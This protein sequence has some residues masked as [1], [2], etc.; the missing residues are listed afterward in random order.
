M[1]SVRPDPSTPRRK[2]HPDW[3]VKKIL[4]DLNQEYNLGLDLRDTSTLTPSARQERAKYDENF[5]R[6]SL[7]DAGVRFLLFKDANAWQN[8]LHGFRYEAR[9]VSQNWIRKPLGDP[10]TLPSSAEIRKATRVGEQLQLQEKLLEFIDEAKQM[11]LA[12]SGPVS[13]IQSD[14]DSPAVHTRSTRSRPKRPSTDNELVIELGTAKR[15]RSQARQQS[16]ILPVSCSIDKVPIRQKVSFAQQHAPTLSSRTLGQSFYNQSANTSKSSFQ[17]SIFSADNNGFPASQQTQTTVD[18]GS[19]QPQ[20]ESRRPAPPSSV[21]FFAPSPGDLLALDESFSRYEAME[22]EVPT[23]PDDVPDKD[24]RPWGNNEPEPEL[25]TNA[26]T[27]TNYTLRGRDDMEHATSPTL[28]TEYSSFSGLLDVQMPDIAPVPQ[29]TV[30]DPLESRLKGI[31][32]MFFVL[33]FS[34]TPLTPFQQ[35]SR[36][37][38][39]KPPYVLFGSSPASVF[40]VALILR[41]W[42]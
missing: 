12:G 23:S 20:K 15:V 9:A 6:W 11:L 28:S 8:A 25:P 21:D 40:I 39:E 34:L 1:A 18:S 2:R 38:S 16:N 37:G 26:T 33:F 42:T 35:R 36:H 7:I 10:D 13:V 27:L 5:R 24:P 29:P 22:D 31:W 32:R 4:R 30:S 3:S 41:A 17:P 19:Q 14:R